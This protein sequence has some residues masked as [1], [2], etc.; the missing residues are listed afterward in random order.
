MAPDLNQSRLTSLVAE[1]RPKDGEAIRH[2]QDK[3]QRLE[4]DNEYL[5]AQLAIANARFLAK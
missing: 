1:L 2:L 4:R 3:V 5:R